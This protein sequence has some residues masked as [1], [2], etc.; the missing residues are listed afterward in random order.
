MPYPSHCE[1]L[2]AYAKKAAFGTAY[3]RV[4]IRFRTRTI[5]I[6]ST[7][8]R[9]LQRIALMCWDTLVMPWM[10]YAV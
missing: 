8:N 7:A 5:R 3:K 2:R 10:L 9:I 1:P 6:D 4:R